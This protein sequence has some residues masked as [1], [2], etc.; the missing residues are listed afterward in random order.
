MPAGPTQSVPADCQL[1][2]VLA[3]QA[4]D[5]GS[6]QAPQMLCVFMTGE[7]IVTSAKKKNTLD[8]I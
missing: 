6:D 2:L 4:G 5:G 1:S 7:L 3:T 8:F